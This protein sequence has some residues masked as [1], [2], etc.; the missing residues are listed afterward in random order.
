MRGMI[1]TLFFG[2]VSSVVHATVLSDTASAHLGH[3]VNR[4][5]RYLKVEANDESFRLVVSLTLGADETLRIMNAADEDGDGTVTQAEADRY[6]AAWGEGLKKELPIERSGE[7]TPVDWGQP[8][9]D[10][11]GPLV[12]RPGTVEMIAILPHDGGVESLT[13]IDRMRVEPYDRTDVVFR[14]QEQAKLLAS[15][16]GRSPTSIDNPLA[17]GQ[18]LGP[19]RRVFTGVFE[20]PPK[21][22]SRAWVVPTVVL[23]VL[24]VVGVGLGAGVARRRR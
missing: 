3:V 15:G 18:E 4:A 14:T 20:T 8:Y 16:S 22:P 1:L 17:Y 13:L 19:E 2:L 23:A 7:A 24:L 21:A 10:P 5:E 12:R 9:F 11:I 6:M